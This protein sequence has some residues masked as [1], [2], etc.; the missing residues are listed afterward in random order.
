MRANTEKHTNSIQVKY[1]DGSY[2]HH[3]KP[4]PGG[5]SGGSSPVS[6]TQVPVKSQQMPLLLFL[7]TIPSLPYSSSQV[8]SNQQHPQIH[9]ALFD[10][11]CNKEAVDSVLQR[12]QRDRHVMLFSLY[13]KVMHFRVHQNQMDKISCLSELA[14]LIGHQLV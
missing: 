3:C 14:K 13:V 2:S 10:K 4:I 9:L 7:P 1:S 8:T 6:I 12:N 5:F 11:S